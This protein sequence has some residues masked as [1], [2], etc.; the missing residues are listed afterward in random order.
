MRDESNMNYHSGAARS[1]VV[2]LIPLKSQVLCDGVLS[3]TYTVFRVMFTML[4]CSFRGYRT[5]RTNRTSL[6]VVGGRV[7][8]IGGPPRQPG[9][10]NYK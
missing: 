2:G 5:S 4:G 3:H 7:I 10:R 6:F 9:H 1:V 8:Q